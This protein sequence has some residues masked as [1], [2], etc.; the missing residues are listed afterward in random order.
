VIRCAQAPDV[1]TNIDTTVTDGY[2]IISWTTGYDGGSSII[3][4]NIQIRQSNG[5]LFSEDT[6]NCDGTNS[7]IVDAA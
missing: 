4:Y 1:P 3:A 7:A 5:V 2:S 6:V